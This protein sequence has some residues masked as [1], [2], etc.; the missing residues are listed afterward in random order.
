VTS[1]TPVD[2]AVQFLVEAGYRRLEMPLTVASVQFE[3]EAALVG[4]AYMPDLVVVVDTVD[5]PPA[6]I[7]QKVEALSRA[8]DVV[9]SRRPLTLV[10]VGPRPSATLL[11]ALGRVCRVL[12]VGTTSGVVAAEQSLRH[13]LSV[14]TP[15]RTFEIK[16]AAADPTAELTSRL[17]DSLHLPVTS[18]LVNAAFSGADSVRSQL[19][20]LFGEP[21]EKLSEDAR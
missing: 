5:E 4:T 17:G 15:L 21:L 2:A 12:P 16:T 7:R 1:T 9:E 11:T 18:Q 8:L 20:R 6:R 14:L 19:R 10:V 13:W 3:F